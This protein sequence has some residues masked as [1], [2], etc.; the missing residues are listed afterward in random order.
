MMK[1]FCWVSQRAAL[2]DGWDLRL[3]GWRL[4]A[5]EPD[6]AAER[7]EHFPILCDYQ[8]VSAAQLAGLRQHRQRM[9]LLG[10]DGGLERAG[11]LA[12]RFADALPGDVGL[13][14]LDQ[15]AERV[16]LQAAA[17]PRQRTA[18]P[19]LLDLFHRDAQIDGRWLGLHPR[20]FALLWHLAELPGSRVTR[21]RLLADVW[22]LNHDPETNRVE[23]HVSRL[24]A[25]LA[26]AGLGQLVVTDPRGG[27]RLDSGDR[28][29]SALPLANPHNA[30]DE[31]VRRGDIAPIKERQGDDN[32]LHKQ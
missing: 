4:D 32:S 2:P 1:Q 14:E 30:L 25:K 6:P 11:L 28:G 7:R 31:Y 8:G 10:V 24:R 9:L 5:A 15:R 13:D 3:R 12:A 26:G 22:R 23:V 20:E 27:Y 16:L 18:G 19:L 21:A 17:M 29:D